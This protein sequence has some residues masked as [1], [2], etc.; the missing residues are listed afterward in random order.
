MRV[1]VVNLID[2]DA[3]IAQGVRHTPGSAFT[4]L[5]RSSHVVGI[6]AHAE[7]GKFAIDP[8]TTSLGMLIFFKH[9]HTGTFTEYKA[10]AHLVPR[11]TG[12]LRII[13]AR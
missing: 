6:R 7:P 11:T 9:Q 5:A 8:R 3:R 1:E 10:G 12:R 4:I 2:I 13:V